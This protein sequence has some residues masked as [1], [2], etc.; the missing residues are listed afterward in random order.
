MRIWPYRILTRDDDE[1]RAD[2]LKIMRHFESNG[3]NFDMVVFIP[4]AGNYLSDLFTEM[5]GKTFDINLIAVRRASTI[6]K[7]NRIKE[8]VF[9]KRLR[10]NIM[11]HVEVFLRLLKYRIGLVP[12][13][14]IQ[15]STDF[16]VVDK[17]VLVIDDSVDTGTTLEMVKSILLEKGARSV[18]TACISNHLIPDEVDVD[19]SVYRY[20]LLRTKN[21]RDYYATG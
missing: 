4:N 10:S 16:K 7:S 20:A 12:K 9:R 13:R 8:F 3:Y 11:R 1:I 18:S 21:S 17:K 2:L 15:P 19:Y 5:F 6:S 14:V